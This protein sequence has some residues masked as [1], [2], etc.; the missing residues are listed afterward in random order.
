MSQYVRERAVSQTIR[1]M[2]SETATAFLTVDVSQVD[3]NPDPD[4][5]LSKHP[6]FTNGSIC[7]FDSELTGIP[8]R[9]L[10][11]IC[12]IGEACQLL[13]DFYE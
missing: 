11:G 10:P 9:H 12:T 2:V 1:D 5:D 4:P 3:P 6:M 13:R 8:N 7:D